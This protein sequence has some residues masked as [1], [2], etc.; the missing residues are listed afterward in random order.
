MPESFAFNLWQMYLKS[1]EKKL[2]RWGI[3]YFTRTDKIPFQKDLITGDKSQNV[4]LITEFLKNANHQFKLNI[5]YRELNVINT[6]LTN[7]K[8]D[9]SLLG[10]VEYAIHEWKGLVAGSFL[11]EVG[12]G[13]EQKRA[14]TYVQVP[15]GQGYYTWKDYNND[16]IAQ[17][18]EFEVAVYQDQ[19]TWIRIFT[20]TDEYVKANYLQ[21]NY[22]FD[23]N[24]SAI[25]SIG[26]KSKMARLLGRFSTNS[27]L[28]I[29]KKDIAASR[30]FE[31]NPFGKS[32]ADTALITLTSFLSNTLYFNRKSVKWGIDI[33]HRLN[34]SKSL[35]NYGFESNKLRD[36]TLKG[37]WNLN[38][39]IATSFTNKFVLNLLNTP[40]FANRNYHIN[41]VS[42]EPSV[43]YIYKS[44]LRVSLIYTYDVRQNKI[45]FMEKAINNEI[46]AEVRY[47]VLS[48]GTLNGRFSFNNISFNGG[49]GGDP[50]STTGYV[51]L[52]GLLPGKNYLWNIEL[53][54]RLA[55]N[56]EVNFQYEGRKPGS[57]ATVH[58]GRASVRAIF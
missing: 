6:G 40:S 52:D 29:N 12:S 58:T 34:T 25:I 44:N 48:N 57:A 36:L 19:K 10:R 3:T 27:A 2:N 49:M 54:K 22:T 13:Q 41:E 18:N 38:R 31:F 11:Y 20:P 39:S 17:L 4:S 37:R 28:Q 50:N 35:L 7:Q 45:D 32:L 47:N 8:S 21:F 33:T 53:T 55:G 43:S 16:G 51:L 46:A 5:T 14:Y 42:S 24:P 1:S 30:S 23:L 15:A 56:I 9:E 26:E